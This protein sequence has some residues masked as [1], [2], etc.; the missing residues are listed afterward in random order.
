MKRMGSTRVLSVMRPLG[1]VACTGV[2][3]EVL[4]IVL[5]GRHLCLV[6]MVLVMRGAQA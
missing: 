1:Q 4:S 3:W 2:L 5:G 6:V